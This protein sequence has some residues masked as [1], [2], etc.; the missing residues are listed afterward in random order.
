VLRAGPRLSQRGAL[1][2]DDV[3]RVDEAIADGVGMGRFADEIV[4]A[5]HGNLARDD[6]RGALRTIFED[7]EEIAARAGSRIECLFLDEGF[8]PLDPVSL[9]TALEV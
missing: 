8:G 3:G 7:L 5:F 9:D 1:E 6:G 4:P 2:P